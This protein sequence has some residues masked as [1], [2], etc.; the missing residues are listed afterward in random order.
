MIAEVKAKREV[1]GK[2]YATQLYQAWRHADN[3]AKKTDDVTVYALVINGGRIG[4]EE[5]I[6]RGVSEHHGT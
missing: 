4:S 1:D 2:F 5:K 6:T 3:L